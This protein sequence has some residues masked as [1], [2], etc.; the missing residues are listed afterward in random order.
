[1][2]SLGCLLGLAGAQAA[3]PAS[4]PAA[5]AAASAAADARRLPVTAK[6]WTGDFDQM[7]ERRRIRVAIPYSRSL[8]FIDKGRER[9][10][11]AE[12]VRDFERWVNKTYAKQLGK[13]PLTVYVASTTRDQLFVALNEGLVDMA[14]GNLSVTDERKQLVDFVAPDAK[15]VNVEIL[16]TGASGPAL[17]SVDELSGQ[18]VHVRES[19]S[20]HA[21]LLALNQRL[22]Q[23]GK[24]P[25]KLV[26]VPDALEDEDMLEMVNA[27]LIGAVVIDQWKARLWASVLPKIELHEDVVLRDAVPTGWAIR[28]NSPQLQAVLNDFYTK[29]VVS[30][31]VVPYR[32]R[33]YMKRIKAMNNSAA[34]AD[35]KRFQDTIA[36]FRKYGAQYGFD[37]LMLAA[38]G[39][40]EST[41]DQNKKS[42]VGAIGVM[43][44][45]PATGAELKVGD[46]KSIEP[47]I[48]GGTKY[49]D[50]LMTR[51]F[52]DAHF[53]ETNRTLFAFASY[54]AGPGNISK[55]R[56]EAEKRG[57]DPDKWFN[58]VELVTAEKIGMETTTYVR[59]I[60]KY[61]VAYR[62][63]LDAE[64]RRRAARERLAPVA[65]PA[66]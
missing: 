65:A 2:V 40:Q 46:I 56:K 60:Y 6:A 23:S 1:M 63:T 48:H 66:K 27:G 17:S 53:S 4:A 33:E 44:I 26:L 31:G 18:T 49:M 29:W 19:S 57:L 30:A 38:Q 43:Q 5:A 52:K 32:Q 58:N 54:N 21:S 16:V 41:L 22:K 42:H 13:R 47:N 64:E 9:G 7:L 37:P 15:S 14:V 59:N 24:P 36:L 34:A 25:V 62:L 3:A 51:Y 61:Y 50:Q 11:S 35:R 28:K 12:L 55:M 45:M 8:Y 20:Y 39:Y 10:L